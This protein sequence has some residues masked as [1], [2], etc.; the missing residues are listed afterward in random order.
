VTSQPALRQ[1]AAARWLVP[2]AVLAAIAVVLFVLALQLQVVLPVIG[3]VY[4]V[5][6]WVAML[7]VS[8]G[9]GTAARRNRSL[10]WFMGALAVGA[11]VTFLG[12]YLVEALRP[13]EQ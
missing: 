1:G 7:I 6:M 9:P 12:I 4:V 10:A 2:S 5:A 3:I 8:R 13:V 11:L